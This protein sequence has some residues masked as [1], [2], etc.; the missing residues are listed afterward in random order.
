MIKMSHAVMI[1][2]GVA[3][4]S[5]AFTN[6]PE[7]W[8]S[9]DAVPSP[10]AGITQPDL[11]SVDAQCDQ[12]ASTLAADGFLMAKGP[13]KC[14]GCAAT[15]GNSCTRVSCNP[16]CYSCPGQPYLVCTE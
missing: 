1:V 16:C 9:R 4:L 15:I 5:L 10:E 13:K 2:I 12:N 3:A 7:R 6:A 14:E 8:A 11:A